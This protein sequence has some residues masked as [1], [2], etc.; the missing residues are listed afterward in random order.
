MTMFLK[1]SCCRYSQ[2]HIYIFWGII[3]FLIYIS[4]DKYKRNMIRLQEEGGKFDR[5]Y[6]IILVFFLSKK[7]KQN[8]NYGVVSRFLNSGALK[9]VIRIKVY[10]RKIYK[11]F[12]FSKLMNIGPQKYASANIFMG[13]LNNFYLQRVR[14][15]HEPRFWVPCCKIYCWNGMNSL[16]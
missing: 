9:S 7:E 15:L 5:S 6:K 11:S 13:L 2:L 10:F 14:L 8:K 16:S 12:M 1:F 4:L 3:T